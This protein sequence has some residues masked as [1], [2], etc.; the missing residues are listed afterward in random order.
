[1]RPVFKHIFERKKEYARL[2][3]FVRMRDERIDPLD[4][5][6]FY[7]CVAFF[8][9]SFGDFN[10]FILRYAQARDAHE[11]MVNVHTYEDENHWLWYLE[12]LTKLGFDK[13]AQGSDWM[14]FLWGE[15]TQQNRILLYRLTALVE[16]TSATERL[17][18]IEAIE[19]T[20]NVMFG[21]MVPCAQKLEQ[22]LGTNLRYCGTY[23]FERETG[24]SIGADHQAL[25]SIALDEETR[26][27]CIQLV[28]RVFDLFTQ[29]THELL[30]YALAHPARA[31]APPVSDERP[32][33]PLFSAVGHDA[34]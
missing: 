7:P 33:F 4:R 21:D 18:I 2:P 1:M 9:M 17:A 20:G 28:D 15:E 8:I 24:H 22:R 25:V 29:W 11:E 12:D 23:H 27:R 10:R 31:S 13:V 19:E 3:L 5:I 16:G 14:R 30:N 34:R 6:A 32:V 26:A